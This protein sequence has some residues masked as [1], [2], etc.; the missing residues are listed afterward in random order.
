MS[1]EIKEG[2][3][4]LARRS[5]ATAGRRRQIAPVA[6]ATAPCYTYMIYHL[7]PITVEVRL[8]PLSRACG[9]AVKPAERPDIAGRLQQPSPGDFV[10][11]L[12]L[13]ER[14]EVR[15]VV[16]LRRLLALTQRD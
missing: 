13:G 8:Q 1:A 14:I 15:V 2:R 11:R 10:V 5:H 7:L 6:A 9:I 12:S 3:F 16:E 4:P